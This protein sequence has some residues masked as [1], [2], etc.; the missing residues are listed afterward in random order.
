LA[1][2]KGN[3]SVTLGCFF[4]FSILDPDIAI[5]EMFVIFN[6]FLGNLSLASPN[7][8]VLRLDD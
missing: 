6:V 4:A 2:W 8:P 1:R 3:G 7:L 5:Q